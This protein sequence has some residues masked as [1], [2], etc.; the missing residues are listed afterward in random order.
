MVLSTRLFSH[1]VATNALLVPKAIT[2]AGEFRLEPE[3]EVDRLGSRPHQGAR[4]TSDLHPPGGLTSPS[5]CSHRRHHFRRMELRV[6]TRGG[7]QHGVGGG[8]VSTSA[9]GTVGPVL[10]QCADANG[11]SGHTAE[12]VGVG[13]VVFGNGTLPLSEYYFAHW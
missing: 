7:P 8:A 13:V 10:L 3:L 6:S 5:Y 11:L 1:P 4:S 9:N 2:S 12:A